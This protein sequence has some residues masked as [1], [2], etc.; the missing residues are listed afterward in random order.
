M[1]RHEC[2]DV[3]EC[4]QNSNICSGSTCVNTW[5]NYYCVQGVLLVGRTEALTGVEIVAATTSMSVSTM[6]GIILGVIITATNLIILAF[7]VYR[8][9]RGL[10]KKSQN[11]T[12]N[13]TPFRAEAGTAKSFNTLASKFSSGLTEVDTIS[14]DSSIS[15]VS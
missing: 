3:N 12:S 4:A 13:G 15:T 6:A 2:E 7:I 1:N 11:K 10:R 14:T 9:G 8:Y 5:G